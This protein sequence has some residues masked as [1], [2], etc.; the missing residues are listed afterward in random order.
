VILSRLRTRPVTI[1]PGVSRAAA[2]VALVFVYLVV[3]RT[4]NI[5]TTFWLLGDQIRDWSIALRP[6]HELPLSGTPSSVG[7]TSFG[8]IFYWTLWAIRVAIGPWTGQLPHAGG[9]GLSLIQSAADVALLL[10]IWKRTGSVTASLAAVLLVA[11]APYDM[12]LSATIWNP[13][14]SVALVKA[15]L[16]VMLAAPREAPLRWT[17]AGVALA[18]LAVQAHS[19]AIFV[20]VPAAAAFVLASPAAPR[21]AVRLARL[22]AALEVV[23]VLQLPWLL[24]A[25]LRQRGA[26]GP[27]TVIGYVG[28]T[29]ADLQRLR[30]SDS[31]GWFAGAAESILFTTNS[32]PWFGVLL[33]AAA[34]AALA[35]WRR[36]PMALA[37]ALAPLLCAVAG[38]AFWQGQFDHYWY[39]TLMPSVA[40][41]FALAIAG[42][43]VRGVPVAAVAV[44]LLVA[45]QPARLATSRQIHR[46]PE[47][48]PLVQGS[49]EIRRYTSEVRWIATQFPLPAT[50]SPT[51]A[52]E[53]LG[54]RVTPEAPFAATIGASGQVLFQ[55]AAR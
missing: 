20:A 7:G 41:L 52:Y 5:S 42:W 13:P 6:W 19:S 3:A 37:A 50:T 28:G 24:D 11:T 17:V 51:F 21:W 27:G 32:A 40:L 34:I 30:V 9:I 31:W 54:G 18:T 26:T 35:R 53:V 48:G 49:A 22:R 36:D 45:A 10:A 4:W 25:L 2:L 8:P 44:L 1:M 12:A 14:L 38:Y 15:T 23:A 16:A 29:L 39:L 43:R 46:L 47:Y 33:A 55:S